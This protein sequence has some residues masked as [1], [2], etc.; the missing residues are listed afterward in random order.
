MECSPIERTDRDGERELVEE[1][2]G[3]AKELGSERKSE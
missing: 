2:R 1:E 3:N